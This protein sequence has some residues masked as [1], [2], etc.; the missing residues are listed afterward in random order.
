MPQ[1]DMLRP[2][3]PMYCKEKWNTTGSINFVN[4]LEAIKVTIIDAPTVEQFRKAISVFMLNSWSEQP[5]FDGFTDE[6]ITSCIRQLFNGEILPTGQEIIGITWCVEGL[7]LVDVTHLIRHRSFSFSAQCS[8]RDLR[9]L[10]VLVK[11]SIMANE[12]VF[13]QYKRLVS[14]QHSLYKDLMDY[15]LACTFDART[16]M[17][18][19]KSH[20]YN[21]R[22]CIKDLI[23]YCNQRSDEQIQT[24]VDNIV[25]L[26]LWLEVVK[27]YPF[28][29]SV[30]DPR[31]KSKY[32]IN[33]CIAGKT[34]IFPPNEN[35]DVFEYSSEQFFHSK[36]RDKFP[37]GDVYIAIRDA[38][39]SE[40]E[41]I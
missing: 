16:V 30:F 27:L 24:Q 18:I 12:A 19:S 10:T 11:P 6:Q 2:Q 9:D 25:A 28:L 36:H 1:N 32:Y 34:T 39:I 17:P 7:D 35:N 8:D 40:I 22:C 33:Q 23:T 26:K 13:E 5:Q 37:G 20:F 15:E 14:E 41:A 38:I 21:V 31:Q 29:K 4:Q 3:E